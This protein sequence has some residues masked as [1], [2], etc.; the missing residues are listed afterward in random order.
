MNDIELLFFQLIIIFILIIILVA[1]WSFNITIKLEKRINKYGI[2]SLKNKPLSVLDKIYYYYQFLLNNFTNLLIKIKIFD[3]YSIKYAKYINFY[4]KKNKTPMYYV[5]TK[6]LFSVIFVLIKIVAD[7][8]E[9]R[10]TRIWEILLLVILGFYLPDLWLKYNN[11][12]KR[13]KIEKDMLNAIIIMNNA[14]KSGLSIMQAIEIV[15][16]ELDGPIKEEFRKMYMELNY[17]LSLEVVFKRFSERVDIEEANYITSSLTILNKTGGNIIKV[18]SS[19]EKS[20]FSKRK[21][22]LE[23]KSLTASSEAM[24]KTLL[25]LP[26]IFTLIILVF[27]PNYFNSLL[28]T[29]IGNL[30]LIIIIAFYG[31]YAYFVRRILRVRM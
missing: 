13:K 15:K 20:L 23:L 26:I 27:N 14:F 25:I 1:L 24:I 22:E 9:Y 30:I 3:Q 21:L 10:F 8:I 2:N 29:E 16:N 19:I 7:I 5:A 28:I 12:L 17:G 6:I 31:L 18:F 4:D 11:Y